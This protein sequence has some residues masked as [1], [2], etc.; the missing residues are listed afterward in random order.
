LVETYD[1]NMNL[2]PGMIYASRE[3]HAQQWPP[4]MTSVSK[5]QISNHIQQVLLKINSWTA[6]KKTDS[7]SNTGNGSEEPTQRP[8]ATQFPPGGSASAKIPTVEV[9]YR[10]EV[11]K[12]QPHFSLPPGIELIAGVSVMPKPLWLHTS[13]WVELVYLDP[14]R[15]SEDEYL[16]SMARVGIRRVRLRPEY[17]VLNGPLST[18][19]A[20][21]ET[22]SAAFYGSHR[23][24]LPVNCITVL[25][26]TSF[27]VHSWR[28][29]L[30]GVKSVNT[31]AEVYLPQAHF[32][33][34]K[35]DSINILFFFVKLL[36]QTEK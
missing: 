16:E 3:S 28:S 31:P 27:T 22:N 5:S 35:Y 32:L 26:P 18:A 12:L 30:P 34:E 24:L 25:L 21:N 13:S 23:M 7:D 10:V 6:Q 11:V 17:T 20:V 19:S 29:Y 1:S 33:I 15:G 4:G 14:K 36:F 2:P 8:S 9:K